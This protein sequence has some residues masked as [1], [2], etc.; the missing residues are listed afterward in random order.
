MRES[1]KRCTYRGW[2]RLASHG[3]GLDILFL[4]ARQPHGGLGDP[5]AERI[6]DDIAAHGRYLTVRYWIA[7]IKATKDAL[8]EAWLRQVMGL[9]EAEFA[10]RYSEITGYLWT[11]E[12]VKVGGHELLDELKAEVGRFCHLEIEYSDA[13]PTY[14]RLS[15]L[16]RA[17][18]ITD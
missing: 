5:L 4:D 8:Q 9:G 10:H 16:G 3:E 12:E 15:A 2:L 7:D 13:E 1:K 18:V 11:D 6:K 17:P 14:P